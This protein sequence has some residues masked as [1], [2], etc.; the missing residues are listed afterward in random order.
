MEI[1]AQLFTVRDF[2][3]NLEDFENTLTRIADIGYKNVQVSGTCEYDAEWLSE[4]LR[5]NGLKCVLT[6]ISP[7]KL[8]ADPKKVCEEHTIFG[9]DYVGLGSYNFAE[10]TKDDFYS[11]FSDVALAI[12][13]NGKYFMYHNHDGEFIKIGGKPVLEHIAELFPSDSLGFTLDTFW[14]QAGGGDPGYWIEK[15]SGRVPCIHLKD[16]AYGR[17]M[18]VVG[19]GNINFDRVFE[20][21]QAAGTKY[22][23]VEQDDCNGENP[24]DCLKRSYEYLKSAGF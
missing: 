23:L 16:F 9:C 24:F 10:N 15:F 3:T 5:K 18:A 14:I 12:S 4:K 21:A 20:K 22:M 2:C 17:K 7:D 19:E 13:E 1:G 8:K 11:E 6:H